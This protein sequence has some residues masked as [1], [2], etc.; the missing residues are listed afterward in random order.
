LES[1]WFT[2]Q[3]G[4]GSSEITK[5]LKQ[6]FEAIDT[7]QFRFTETEDMIDPQV[8]ANSTAEALQNLN[9]RFLMTISEDSAP[10]PPKDL[11]AKVMDLKNTV[12]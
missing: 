3:F 12:K 11:E 8:T 9:Q 2:Q 6:A 4:S 5:G 7:P 10:L 1:D